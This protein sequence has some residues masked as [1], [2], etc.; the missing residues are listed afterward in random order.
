MKDQSP[1]FQSVEQVFNEFFEVGHENGKVHT[2]H[3]EGVTGDE[4]ES[5]LET[6]LAAVSEVEGVHVDQDRSRVYVM[7]SGPVESLIKVVKQAGYGV[8]TAH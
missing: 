3:L 4:D 7:S 8:K 2:L 6:A 1:I 5:I